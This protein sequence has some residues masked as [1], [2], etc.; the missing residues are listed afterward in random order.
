MHRLACY[1]SMPMLVQ[2][3]SKLWSDA[4]LPGEPMAI[5]LDEVMEI[6]DL[7]RQEDPEFQGHVRL[8]FHRPS[9]ETPVEHELPQVL[10]SAVLATGR[11]ASRAGMTY[12]TDAAILGQADIPSVIFGPGGAG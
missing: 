4:L 12:W 8:L 9:Y 5:A 2:L 1:L 7:L 11:K 10:E 6:L 3:F